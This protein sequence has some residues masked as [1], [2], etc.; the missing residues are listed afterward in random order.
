[1]NEDWVK[2]LSF[3]ALPSAAKVRFERRLMVK[4]GTPTTEYA[5]RSIAES[6]EIVGDARDYDL[7]KAVMGPLENLAKQQDHRDLIVELDLTNKTLT[8]LEQC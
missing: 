3:A 6:G 4:D 8:G 5:L 7:L 1:M 2:A